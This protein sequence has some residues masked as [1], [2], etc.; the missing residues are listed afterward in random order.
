MSRSGA[1][2]IGIAAIAPPASP[3]PSWPPLG[4]DADSPSGRSD[5]TNAERWT[6]TAYPAAW[7]LAT[8]TRSETGAGVSPDEALPKLMLGRSSAIERTGWMSMSTETFAD[9]L[10]AGGGAPEHGA[11][12]AAEFRGA[13]AAAAKSLEFASVSVQPPPV[14][15]AAVVLLSAG[16]ATPPS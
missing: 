6:V 3:L 13:G 9:T 5:G 8:V 2:A 4:A 12:A 14:R 1:G 10:S 11:A 15:M 16:S 7:L